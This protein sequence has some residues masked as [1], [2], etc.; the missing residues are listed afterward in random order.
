MRTEPADQAAATSPR[1]AASL[2]PGESRWRRALRLGGA[3]VTRSLN[4]VLTA[5]TQIWANKGRSLLTTLGIIIAVTAIIV[6][7]TFVQGFGN[8][9]TNML[10]GYGTQYM[11][12]SPDVRWFQQ[13]TGASN[14]KMTMDDV[15]AVRTNCE[16]V[17]R[18]TPFLY[19]E[20]SVSCGKSEV[21]GIPLRGVTQDYQVIR[22]YYVDKGRFFGPLDVDR[23]SDVCVVGRNV[24]K[25]LDIDDGI[26]DGIIKISGRRFRVV[27]AL[28]SK[29]SFMGDDQ[30]LTIM[31]PYSTMLDMYPE[32]RDMIR[33]LAEAAGE[34]K[35]DAVE[36]QIRRILRQRHRLQPGQPDD[37]EIERQDQALREFQ[38]I[39]NVTTGVLAGIV[40]IS[41]LVGGIGIMNVMLVSVTERTREIGLRKS[42]GGRRRDIMLQ[43][44]IEAVVLST[45]GGAAGIAIGYGISYIAGLHPSMVDLS[46]PLWSV[47]LALFFSAGAGIL[48]GIIP[49]FKAPMTTLT[50]TSPALSH[51]RRRTS[52]PQAGLFDRLGAAGERHWQNLV[53]ALVQIWANKARAFL[54]TL[55][56]I[57]AVTS[58][59]TVVSMVQGFGD[60]MTN[61]LRNFGT[62]MMFVFP[63][64]PHAERG[65]FFTRVLLDVGD[66]REVAMRC[67]KVRRIS[68]MVFSAATVE[69]GRQ[70]LTGV[71]MRGATEEFQS[72][73]RFYTD[74][75][76]FFGPLEVDHGQYVCVLGRDIMAR[77]ECDERIVGDHVFLNGMRFLVLGL[78][79]SK[80]SMFG[81]KQDD[82]VLIPFTTA[83]KL[84]PLSRFFMPFTL[85]CTSEND[86]EECALQVTRVLRERHGLGPGE[87]NDFLLFRQDEFLRDFEKVRL[88]ATSVLAGI[89]GISLI[90]GGIGVMNVM[91]V[92]VTE[93]T[94]EIGLRK[95]VGARRRD[96]LIQF[97][98]EAIVLATVGGAIG[99]GLGYA[100]CL[101]ASQ[102]PVMVEVIVPWW[103]VALA[104]GFS[105]TV[106]VVFGIIPAFKAAILHPID[107]LRHE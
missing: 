23:A 90:V 77:L 83:L 40:S 94:R 66:V 32:Q 22:N 62:N 4:S 16:D 105:A 79:E 8:Y 68:P 35:I 56:I 59:I 18:L 55:G 34:E 103:A 72:I 15:Q 102:H 51:P 47:A 33:F 78:L 92:S 29:G 17:R 85:E 67:D 12:V 41:L 43:F 61:M 49:A 69:Y 46:V 50:G 7:V 107:A 63:Y 57:I 98:T 11:V 96:I 13:V 19:N 104:L 6:V 30:D 1:R 27:G 20:V 60:Y 80:G 82:M 91:L 45:L 87:P 52:A 81:D 71:K 42:V 44:L 76:R 88:I 89:V 10:R 84:S 54:T 86:V 75:G 25:R 2:G 48:F 70:R 31:V 39:R 38:K 26:V 36:A 74:K 14:V 100:I 95:S 65:M 97:L 58:T 24:L 21:S 101:I 3:V 64:D 28:E 73:R 9:M 37:F 106:G 93:R 5:F 53:T 99:V